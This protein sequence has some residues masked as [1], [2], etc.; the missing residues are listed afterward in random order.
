MAIHNQYAPVSRVVF[1]V[2]RSIQYHQ[3][4]IGRKQ[5]STLEVFWSFFRSAWITKFCV[6]NLFDPE[7]EIQEQTKQRD[8]TYD[9]L[10]G[11]ESTNNL[12]TQVIPKCKKV[13]YQKTESGWIEM[14]KIL[15]NVNCNLEAKHKTPLFTV[16]NL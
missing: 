10:W 15:P 5:Y 3:N 2:F 14:K 1:L 9:Q 7:K 16:K 4:F 11:F 13:R 12:Q 8:K 6:C